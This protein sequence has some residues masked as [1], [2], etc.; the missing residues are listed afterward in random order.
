MSINY[1][2]EGRIA[3]F[4]IDRTKA[5]NSINVETWR[6]IQ[7]AMI[8]FRD[9]PELWVGIVTGAGDKAFCAG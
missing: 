5:F 8:D 1:Q 2:K 3:I 6:E 9:D 4:T 7:E